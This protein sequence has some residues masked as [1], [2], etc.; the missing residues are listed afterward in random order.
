MVSINEDNETLIH[1]K[2][3]MHVFKIKIL[4][5]YQ[6]GVI[7]CDSFELKSDAVATICNS[8]NFSCR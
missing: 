5:R 1:L 8:A 6:S 4:A 7:S 2:L 3:G